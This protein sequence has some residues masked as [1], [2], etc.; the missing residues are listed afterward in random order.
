MVILLNPSV[1][2]YILI[3]RKREGTDVLRGL[4]GGYRESLTGIR[5]P[6]LGQLQSQGPGTL[7]FFAAF[8]AGW[9][10]ALSMEEEPFSEAAV[11]DFWP[12]GVHTSGSDAVWSDFSMK[13]RFSWRSVPFLVRAF[14]SWQCEHFWGIRAS[15]DALTV[16]VWKGYSEPAGTVAFEPWG[17]RHAP[18]GAYSLSKMKRGR[19]IML[20][21]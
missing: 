9:S 16:P 17:A 5:A 3:N 12:G 6:F 19:D 21:R 11:G 1:L 20:L 14:K 8:L 15:P 18:Q 13:R 10:G 4:R 7:V 2:K